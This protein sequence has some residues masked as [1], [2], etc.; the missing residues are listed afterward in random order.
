[1]RKIFI[2]IFILTFVTMLFS[3]NGGNI[4]YLN[5]LISNGYI[6]VA[7]NYGKEY[8]DDPKIEKALLNLLLEYGKYKEIIKLCQK[9]YRNNL[10]LV[11]AT[12]AYIFMKQFDKAL[13]GLNKLQ[14][15]PIYSDLFNLYNGMILLKKFN[16]I[17]AIGYLEKIKNKSDIV[18]K[19]LVKLYAYTGS[20]EKAQKV[21]NTLKHPSQYL[22]ALILYKS[23]KFKKA[24]EELKKVPPG[25]DKFIL[26]YNSYLK[27][28]N[29]K[30]AE[31]ILK[32]LKERNRK[33]TFYKNIKVLIDYK[34]YDEAVARLLK[35][36]DSYNKYFYLGEIYFIKGE[37]F[38]AIKYYQLALNFSRNSKI[39]Y[40]I[41]LSYEKN[42]QLS[43]AVKY[44]EK[45][46]SMQDSD[47]YYINSLYKAGICY[48]NIGKFNESEKYLL[49]YLEN[50]NGLLKFV[51]ESLNILS[52]IYEKE[53]NFV[54]CIDILN[55]IEDIATDKSE[56]RKLDFRIAELW[57]KLGKYNFAANVYRKYFPV[58]DKRELFVLRKLGEIYEKAGNYNG[59][60]I[61]LLEYINKMD[62]FIPEIYLKIA[63]NYLYQNKVDKSKKYLLE[64]INNEKSG[65]FLEE[66]LFYMGRIN[67][68]LKNYKTAVIY[69]NRLYLIN[70]FSPLS[71]KAVK[72]LAYS[73]FILNDR[74]DFI[75][76][77]NKL[78]S[79]NSF[80]QEFNISL[81][82][83]SKF[84]K[85]RNK[86]SIKL[87]DE[88]KFDYFTNIFKELNQKSNEEIYA[89]INENIFTGDK[90]I[91]YYYAGKILKKR[92][93]EDRAVFAFNKFLNN[94]FVS[95]YYFEY[96]EILPSMLL[97]YFTEKDFKK[98]LNYF[99][100]FSHIDNL[101]TQSLFIIGYSAYKL[102]LDKV[103]QK[104][105]SSFITKSSNGENLFK[106]AFTLDRLNF[107]DNAIAGYKK[108]LKYLKDSSTKMEA[109]YWLGEIFQKKGKLNQALNY[110]LQIKL[111]FPFDI[112]W[113]PTASFQVAKIFESLG[114]KR[115]A[116]KE[117]S[118]IFNHLKKDDPRKEFVANRIKVLKGEIVNGNH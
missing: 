12:K 31:S 54:K 79:I 44:Y 98:I 75:K 41:A 104:Y 90:V 36:N 20:T 35:A 82:D 83:I 115:K 30:A 8:K 89:F 58:K 59:S 33:S 99:P 46:I 85:D 29:L 65:T 110:F 102:R 112:K 108:A 69:F 13:I 11:F 32:K 116:F 103:S 80:I 113:T 27:I 68:N 93:L 106:A 17:S 71:L 114:E 77:F 48:Y 66:A 24:I 95:K 10:E 55:K 40:K 78:P 21:F 67:Y 9:G 42:H 70:R 51:A 15:K 84:V 96:K 5:K 37:F 56:I 81:N 2:L 109:L 94:G 39:F 60:N 86:L 49:A 97:Y 28:G 52:N 34:N 25:D 3:S 76:F 45:V 100:I 87:P 72:Y 117:Y 73:Y 101:P 23:H 91:I 118:Y 105:L 4:T 26:L 14:N 19:I 88:V 7:I 47:F 74:E 61:F 62:R 107:Y 63:L 22:Y 111:L 64:I 57:I 38:K 6:D 53:G 18:K 16:Y 50:N 43:E 92:G 1:M